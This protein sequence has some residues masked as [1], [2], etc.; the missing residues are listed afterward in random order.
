MIEW[1]TNNAK[2]QVWS[3]IIVTKW[4]NIFYYIPIILGISLHTNLSDYLL[5]TMQ[6]NWNF[7]QNFIKQGPFDMNT[8]AQ[9]TH[10]NTNTFSLIWSVYFQYLVW[11]SCLLF[12]ISPMCLYVAGYSTK[13]LASDAWRLQYS[14]LPSYGSGL[15]YFKNCV[16]FIC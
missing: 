2:F 9:K 10:A 3:T 12:I 16:T 15:L 11:Y 8:Q 13:I 4:Q 6:W 7:K 5:C 14:L 1:M